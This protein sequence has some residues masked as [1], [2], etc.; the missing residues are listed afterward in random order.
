M[1]EIR[2]VWRIIKGKKHTHL[3]LH[4]FEVQ[5]ENNITSWGQA[6]AAYLMELMVDKAGTTD[7]S[8]NESGICE[9]VW[10]EV[11]DLC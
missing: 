4:L 10:R 7:I 1:K 6:E 8:Y 9:G 5:T 11:D 2:L 3:H